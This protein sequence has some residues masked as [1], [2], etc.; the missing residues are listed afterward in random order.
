MGYAP[1]ME[2][3]LD[4]KLAR[5]QTLRFDHRAAIERSAF[6]AYAA[7]AAM[8]VFVLVCLAVTSFTWDHRVLGP[9]VMSLMALAAL[10]MVI[11]GFGLKRV[12]SGMEA[13]AL[14]AAISLPC[15]E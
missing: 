1:G 6:P 3:A 5:L 8:L 2:R 12:G 15:P 11:R 13:L 9:P 4:G 14:S 7:L 10:G